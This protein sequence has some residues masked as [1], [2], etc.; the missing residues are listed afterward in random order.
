MGGAVR[1]LS[2]IR[3]RILATTD[4]VFIVFDGTDTKKRF[5][6]IPGLTGVPPKVKQNYRLVSAF[7]ELPRIYEDD[8][9]FILYSAVPRTVPELSF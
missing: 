9:A 7:G 6:Q 8:K 1:T 5:Y 2:V 4:S 3:D